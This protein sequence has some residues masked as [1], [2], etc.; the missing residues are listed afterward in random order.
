MTYVRQPLLLKQPP[1]LPYHFIPPAHYTSLSILTLAKYNTLACITANSTPFPTAPYDMSILSSTITEEHTIL[2]AKK[3]YSRELA[4][5][6]FEQYRVARRA[7]DAAQ[8]REREKRRLAAR[9]SAT[10]SPSRTGNAHSNAGAA[11]GGRGALRSGHDADDDRD[12]AVGFSD[13]DTDS[14]FDSEDDQD[15]PAARA[16]NASDA[17][18][19]HMYSR[20]QQ[21]QPHSRRT[22]F[23]TRNRAKALNGKPT[24]R[25]K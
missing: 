11:S 13:S 17:A 23:L 10:T 25:S 12:D 14:D 16:A 6:T 9:E 2:L 4:A 8:E 19:R 21:Q 24:Q 15:T 1:P 3:R 18:A 20:E 5:Y 22:L 7:S